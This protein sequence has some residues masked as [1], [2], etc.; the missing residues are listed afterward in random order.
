MPRDFGFQLER[1]S[2]LMK[3]D[4]ILVRIWRRRGAD[5]CKHIVFRMISNQN[6]FDYSDLVVD[7]IDIIS[8]YRRRGSISGSASSITGSP[9]E[10]F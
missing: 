8:L 1:Y 3:C 4:A 5:E 2:L 9:R 6:A 10:A 7:T